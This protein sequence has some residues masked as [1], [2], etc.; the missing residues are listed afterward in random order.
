MIRIRLHTPGWLD[1]G[2][3]FR[4]NYEAE[5]W[6]ELLKVERI[7]GWNNDADFD[8]WCLSDN[9]LMAEMKPRNGER[10]YWVIAYV[11][12][13][14]ELLPLPQWVSPSAPD[15]GTPH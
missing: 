4:R 10:T 11:D 14:L 9:H 7:A 12:D 2:D 5:S 3:D 1:V 15:A 6:D 13:G 8:H